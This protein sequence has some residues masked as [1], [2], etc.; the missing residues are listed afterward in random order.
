M[1]EQKVMNRR[2]DSPGI[3]LLTGE[4]LRR[5]VILPLCLVLATGLF[6][7]YSLAATSLRAPGTNQVVFQ[8]GLNTCRVLSWQAQHP[9]I[10]LTPA[11]LAQLQAKIAAHTADW[12]RWH[13]Y[14]VNT[15]PTDDWAFNPIMQHALVYRLHNESN[16]ALATQHADYAL[17]RMQELANN[18]DGSCPPQSFQMTAYCCI[19]LALGYDWL[20]DYPG[21]TSAIKAQV[22]GALEPRL[23]WTLDEYNLAFHNEHYLNM[24]AEGLAGYAL[25]GD[26]AR[27]QT[28][29]DHARFSRFQD[30]TL[31][32]LDLMGRGGGWAEGEQYG[33][34]ALM[35]LTE[36]MMAV[37]SAS[38]EDLFATSPY[39]ADQV[40]HIVHSTAP[41]WILDWGKAT[42]IPHLRGDTDTRY[43]TF[44]DYARY[45]LLML[46]EALATPSPV[47]D[48]G[49]Q[50][51]GAQPDGRDAAS[52]LARG[53]V[54]QAPGNQMQWTTFCV[55]DFLWDNPALPASAVSDQP[56]AHLEEGTGLAFMR[57]DWSETA[58]WLSFQA[59]DHFSAHQHRDQNSFTIYR[60]GRLAIDSGAYDYWCSEHMLNYQHQSIA[61][62][63]I[64][65]RDPTEAFGTVCSGESPAINVEGQRAFDP[66]SI[67]AEDV[68]YWQAAAGVYDTA[69]ILR[70]DHAAD[71]SYT[72]A[73]GEATNAYSDKVQLFTREFLY[74]R[75][76]VVV[77][78]DRVRVSDPAFTPRWV[79]HTVYTPT[80]SGN[81]VNTTVPGHIVTYDGNLVTATSGHHLEGLASYSGLADGKLFCRTLLPA[82]HTITLIGG[83]GYEAWVDGVNSP[84]DPGD[85][86][87]PG[88]WRV[89]VRPTAATTEHLFLH[90]LQ[91]TDASV[92]AIPE[93]ALIEAGEMVGAHIKSA[94]GNR[95]ALFSADIEAAAPTGPIVYSFQPTA[96]TRHLLLDLVPGASYNVSVQGNDGTQTVTVQGPIS[97]TQYPIPNTKSQVTGHSYFVTSDQGVLS[98]TTA[99]PVSLSKGPYL[100]SVT[101]NSIVVVWETDVPGDSV[102]EYGPTSA[103]GFAATEAATTTHHAV[104]IEGLSRYTIYHYRVLT[105][106]SALSDD[107]TFKTA[108]DPTQGTF[109]FA[110]Y[111]DNRTNHAAHQS[112][113]DRALT[114]APDFVLDTGDLVEDGT[115]A[116]Q[117]DTFFDIERELLRTAPFFPCLGNHER[118]SAHYFDLFHLPNNERYYS[119]DYGH[120][121]IVALEVDG[122]QDYSAGSAQYNWLASDLAGTS[123]P[124]RFVFFHFPPYS[125]GSHGDDLTAQRDLVP[126]FEQYGVQIVFN[127]HDHDYER[128]LVNGVNYIVAGGGG[129]PLYSV[130][131]G[132][133]TVYAESTLH[134]VSIAVNEH[135]LTSVGV[136]PDGTTFDQFTMTCTPLSRDLD[137]DCDVDVADIMIV[138]SRWH[139]SVGEDDYNPAYDLDD[140]GDVDIVDIMLVAVR[141]GERCDGQ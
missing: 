41:D 67:E 30:R 15:L 21:F 11:K 28:Y 27:A 132:P 63:T 18:V 91:A 130:T 39:F 111:G 66:Y 43:I 82:S 17:A 44:H 120:A 13:D 87:Q 112:V 52:R 84:Y 58:A 20:Y 25:H 86:H 85:R 93:V 53:Y 14:A 37:R 98:F 3:H 127:G 72:Y 76:D 139:S 65:V 88:D 12:Q 89:E 79:L 35:H 100:Q 51:G 81:V 115:V 74:L 118:N 102:V 70:Y 68:E 16:P 80:V 9:R 23:D 29:I 60:Q 107:S 138:A 8:Q 133:Y 42:R 117:W 33:L 69:D 110:V 119:F 108:A 92:E 75:P 47:V 140:D 106:G 135:T 59:G 78:F 97:N 137:C 32:A 24:L 124:W 45:R 90:V 57:S 40:R 49:G 1:D 26:S 109:S 22:R 94:G 4:A 95:L 73:L 48:G 129:A 31:P 77:V 6:L 134:V 54:N 62:N 64:A 122:Y 34:G 10:W 5:T 55:W 7:S 46:A 83:A 141:W 99:A 96:S 19:D 2:E 71:E 56:L 103:Y 123:Q 121:H 61:H 36:Y 125:S 131:G 105:N 128:S 50:G 113:V 116:G 136:R 38:G 104:T 126:L 101:P 114:L